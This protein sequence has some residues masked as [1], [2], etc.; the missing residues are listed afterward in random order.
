M[1]HENFAKPTVGN[2]LQKRMCI[3]RNIGINED[4]ILQR[5]GSDFVSIGETLTGAALPPPEVLSAVH[6]AHKNAVWSF[7][8]IHKAS[9]SQVLCHVVPLWPS[10]L[11][12]SRAI[13]GS[14]RS[15]VSGL[16]PRCRSALRAKLCWYIGS[17]LARRQGC[18]LELAVR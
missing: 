13:L 15:G 17:V 8:L 5:N 1:S 11:W 18:S 4:L 9:V 3:L 14:D 7:C 2:Y 6:H 10:S 12:R 16:P